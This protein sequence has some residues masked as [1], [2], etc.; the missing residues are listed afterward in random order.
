[1]DPNY[2]RI[3]ADLYDVQSGRDVPNRA[4]LLETSRFGSNEPFT[5]VRQTIDD[6][7]RRLTDREGLRLRSDARFFLLLNLTEIS[8]ATR[9]SRRWPPT[10]LN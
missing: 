8:P 1:M 2:E 4:R 7:D 6:A 5:R 3:F 9:W 10:G